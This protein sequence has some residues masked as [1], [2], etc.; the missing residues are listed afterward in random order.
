MS[1]ILLEASP[2][3]ESSPAASLTEGCDAPGFHTMDKAAGQHSLPVA[4]VHV[5]LHAENMSRLA[6]PLV[7]GL[8]VN[9][10][11]RQDY[12]GLAAFAGLSLLALLLSAV[13]QMLA[14]R[15]YSR[16]RD[17]V[18]QDRPTSAHRDRRRAWDEW[19]EFREHGAPQLLRAGN[20]VIGSLALLA[21]YDWR[22]APLCLL[23]VVPAALLHA[24]HDRR[25]SLLFSRAEFEEDRDAGERFAPSVHR[26]SLRDRLVQLSDADAL[27]VCLMQLFVLGLTAAALIQFCSSGDR[28]PGDLL[29]V[30]GYLWLFAAGLVAAPQLLASRASLLRRAVAR[31]RRVTTD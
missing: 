27:H 31:D 6:Q 29:A 7:L 21:W 20:N 25:V 5:L 18:S 12:N 26:R 10:L 11:L 4:I 22:I 15:V 17:T 1:T 3:R 16:I 2:T 8:A 9:D 23:L 28:L 14:S 24:A 19:L 13:R 30:L